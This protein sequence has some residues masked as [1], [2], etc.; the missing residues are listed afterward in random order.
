MHGTFHDAVCLELPQLL[1]QHLL[2]YAG[3]ASLEV[4][5]ALHLTAKK[6]EQ[7]YQL[8][9]PLQHAETRFNID[10]RT[11]RGVDLAFALTQGT[12]FLVGTS[13]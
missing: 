7:D 11:E 6:V 9:P 13:H 4:R 3:H 10:G 8:P 12:Y 2:R 1:G 5:E